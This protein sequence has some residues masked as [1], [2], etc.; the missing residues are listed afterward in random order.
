MFFLI[1]SFAKKKLP[2]SRRIKVTRNFL[3]LRK[4]RVNAGRAAEN[5]I[6]FHC[7]FSSQIPS[8]VSALKIY[9]EIAENE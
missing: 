5:R 1:H 2:A 7:F 4:Y 9:I 8:A 3:A 6:S